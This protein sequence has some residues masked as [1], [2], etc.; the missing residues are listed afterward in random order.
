LWYEIGLPRLARKVGADVVFSLTNYLPLFKRLPSLLLVQ[1]AGHFSPDFQACQRRE[2]PAVTSRIAWKMKTL[3]VRRSID[4]ATMVTVQTE[5]LANAISRERNVVNGKIRVIPHGLGLL[6]AGSPRNFSGGRTWRIGFIT[7]YGVQK[8]FPTLFRAVASLRDAGHD[9]SLVL[10]LDPLTPQYHELMDQAKALGIELCI[11]NHGEVDQEQ[12]VGLYDSLD[13]FAFPSLCE[14]F[15]FP[16]VE[17]M[18]RGIPLLVA[19]TPGNLEIAGEAALSFDSEDAADLA[20]K[21]VC[22]M[23]DPMVYSEASL[24]SFERARAFSWRKA[25]E[26]TLVLLDVFVDGKRG[27]KHGN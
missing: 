24:A 3:W 4:N 5:A 17:A 15:G 2:Y 20:G 6:E 27:E 21:I 18:S 23:S 10:T 9:I 14:S 26:A 8:N 11:E 22:I 19:D 16:M 12:I 7:K 13:V 25:A 1:H